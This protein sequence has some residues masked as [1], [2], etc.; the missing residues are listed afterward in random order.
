M[1]NLYL[2][3]L[4][5]KRKNDLSGLDEPRIWCDSTKVYN[6]AVAKDGTDPINANFP[7][8]GDVEVRCEEMNGTKGKQIGDS[9]TVRESGNP[10][11]L[12]FKT[13]GT[14]YEVDFEVT[15]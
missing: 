6:G 14:W 3:Q 12:T 5:C 4:R 8:E 2:K 15:A 1:A 11:F 7:F 10:S 9:V 13:A